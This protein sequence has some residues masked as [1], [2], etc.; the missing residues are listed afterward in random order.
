LKENVVGEREK[1]ETWG[2]NNTHENS[3][4]SY[5]CREK[6][7]DK[8]GVKLKHIR[9][10]CGGVAPKTRCAQGDQNNVKK[11]GIKEKSKEPEKRGHTSV[12]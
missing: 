1:N 11:G 10:V 9:L 8:G 6:R 5:N 4:L 12:D 7:N 2:G 3:G